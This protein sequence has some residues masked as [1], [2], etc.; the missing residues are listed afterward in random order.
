MVNI[1]KIA[2]KDLAELVRLSYKDD[3]AG[4]DKFHVAKYSYEQA[5]T[6]TLKMIA[7]QQQIK[8]M[9]Y[10]GIYYNNEAIGYFVFFSGVLYSFAI[11]KPYRIKRGVL[12]NWWEL[13]KS[14]ME[15]HFICVLYRNNTR[16]IQFL[17]RLGMN[18][19]EYNFEDK[20]L[21][22]LIN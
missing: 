4:F 9:E 3:Q 14:V 20:N 13:A 18:E 5:V 1:K 6:R 12:R 21:I 19:V 16:A 22:T 2:I 7:D 15:D 11:S 10:Y 17:K 8:P